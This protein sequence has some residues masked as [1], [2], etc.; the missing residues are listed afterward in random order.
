MRD[1]LIKFVAE[2]ILGNRADVELEADDDLFSDG[3]IDSM[4][5]MRLMAF[6]ESQYSLTVPPEDMTIENFRTI[7]TICRYAQTRNEG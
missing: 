4:G 7:E 6:L 2:E 1:E 3:L 5:I